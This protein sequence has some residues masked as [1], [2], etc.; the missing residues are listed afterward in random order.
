M[1]MITMTMMTMGV[2]HADGDEN[3]GAGGKQ[4]G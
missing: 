1:L 3:G 4:K 2:G